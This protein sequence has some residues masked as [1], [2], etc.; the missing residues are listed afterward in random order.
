MASSS[1]RPKRIKCTTIKITSHPAE[2]DGW[3][4]DD[5][6]QDNF[7]KNWK[8]RNI[9]NPK[10]IDIDFFRDNGFQF[11]EHFAYQSLKKFVQLRGI[12]YPNLL[13]VFYANA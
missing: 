11:Q 1:S 7:V 6:Q 9:V 2:L 5:E 4:S 13:K 10:Y 3:I 8:D 12:Y